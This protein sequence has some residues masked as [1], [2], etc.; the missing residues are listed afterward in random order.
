LGF[1]SV[2][3]LNTKK[4]PG[5][6][7]GIEPWFRLAPVASYRLEFLG[8][9]LVQKFTMRYFHNRINNTLRSPQPLAGLEKPTGLG[10]FHSSR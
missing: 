3:I 1:K 10:S 6:K 5:S 8:A 2:Q 9:E 7:G 4:T